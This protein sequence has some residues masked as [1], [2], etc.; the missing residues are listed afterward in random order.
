MPWYAAKRDLPQPEFCRAR[1]LRRRRRPRG[2]LRRAHRGGRR[3]RRRLLRAGRHC[4]D[5]PGAGARRGA[6]RFYD[7]DTPVTVARAG[8]TAPRLS[9]AA[10]DPGASTSICRSP[11]GRRCDAPGAA[12]RRPPRRAALLRGRRRR[13]TSPARHADALGPRLS[14]H[15]QPGPPA[16]AGA[17]ADRAGA[18]AAATAA[19]W[20]PDRNIRP[21]IDWPANVERI[22]HLP[23]AD[24]A[25]FYCR[26]RFTLN[27][28]RADMVAAGWSPSVRLFE[29][30]A[31][32][33]PIISDRW[34]GLERLL[35]DG[36][37]ILIADDGPR[38][39][40]AS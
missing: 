4:G 36:E 3:G 5:R 39:C 13:A 14:R 11:A 22:E 21:T 2:A 33:T 20:S 27:V 10:P 16:G 18:A 25:A 6:A 7:I 12:V 17:A 19:S 28:T 34:A 15:L 9:R 37:A 40:P 26:Q 29:A 31:C 32:G 24:H 30:A 8:A 1:A 35:P 38:R 23:P